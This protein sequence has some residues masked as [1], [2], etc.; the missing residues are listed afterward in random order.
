MKS[1]SLVNNDFRL[2]LKFF[3]A[4]KA[5]DILAFQILK[6]LPFD[7]NLISFKSLEYMRHLMTAIG[8]CYFDYKHTYACTELKRN[9]YKL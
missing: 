9:E 2:I 1:F 5:P 7:M 3:F 6:C 8:D 4:S